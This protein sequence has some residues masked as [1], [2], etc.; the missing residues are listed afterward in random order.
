MS[1]AILGIRPLAC[2][3]TACAYHADLHEA[4]EARACGFRQ[5]QVGLPAHGSF[6]LRAGHIGHSPR[7][8]YGLY[9]P[10]R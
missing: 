10:A 7:Y 9:S 4:T 3:P 6:V 5:Q 1:A 2:R 8:P